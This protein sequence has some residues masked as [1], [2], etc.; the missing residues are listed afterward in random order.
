[1]PQ[2][3]YLLGYPVVLQILNFLGVKYRT[4]HSSEIFSSFSD[5][6]KFFLLVFESGVQDKIPLSDLLTEMHVLKTEST[7]VHQLF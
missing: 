3:I 5:C 4:Y 6:S 1:M 7:E 2:N